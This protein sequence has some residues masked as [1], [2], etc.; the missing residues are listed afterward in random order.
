M[1]YC[2]IAAIYT[3][4]GSC[5]DP[6]YV[7]GRSIEEGRRRHERTLALALP[8]L[9][10]RPQD[11][12]CMEVP[13][14]EP[15]YVTQKAVTARVMAPDPAADLAGAIVLIRSADPGY[16]WLFSRGIAGLITAYGGVNSHM[17]IRSGEL[18]IPAVIGAG[19]A[20]YERAAAASAVHIDCANRSLTVLS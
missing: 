4:H 17:A 9:I 12:R 7:I 19:E 13:A 18:Q 16:D 1:S 14:T 6:A 10:V 20:L 3:L 11:A 8:S 5:D 2:S 15:N